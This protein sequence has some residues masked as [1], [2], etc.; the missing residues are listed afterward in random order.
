M[1]A[2]ESVEWGWLCVRVDVEVETRVEKSPEAA[3]RKPASASRVPLLYPTNGCALKSA[4]FN[5]KV[6]FFRKKFSL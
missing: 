1:E 3:G 4:I 5:Q 2:E 6:E